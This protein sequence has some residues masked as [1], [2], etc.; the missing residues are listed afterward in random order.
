MTQILRITSKRAGFRRGGLAHPA[1][2]VD[3][4]RSR[5][6]EEQ[7]AE[8]KAEPMLVVEEISAGKQSGK[9]PDESARKVPE[10]SREDL[11]RKAMR[12]LDSETQP[13]AFTGSG[14]PKTEILQEMTGLETVSAKERDALWAE[15]QAA[16]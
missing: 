11:L 14:K 9:A 8:L 16:A 7:I 2:A 5:F 13:T 15:V 12:D 3:H 6:T 4:A 1:E 10:I